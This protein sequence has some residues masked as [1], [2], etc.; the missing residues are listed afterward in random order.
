[1]NL[2][3]SRNLPNLCLLSL[4][5]LATGADASE[6]TFSYV[7][8][9]SVLAPGERELEPWTT[10]RLGRGG[11][12]ARF[13]QRLEFE[14]GLVERLQ[15]AWYLNFGGTGNAAGES[16]FEF[17]GV[18]WEWKYKLLDPV[19]DPVG[20]AVYLELG[21][22]PTEAEVEGKLLLDKKFGDLL[23]AL[24][25]VGEY[26]WERG[27][28]GLKREFVLELDAGISWK[29]ASGL[30]IGL[31]ARNHN[32]FVDGQWEHVAIFLGP[33]F[34]YATRSFWATLTLLP[35][36]YA[37][38]AEDGPG[39]ELHEHERLEARLLFGWHL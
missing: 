14:I 18:S 24:N 8:D 17:K 23:V 30:G 4:L 36:V 38:H 39:L 2:Q 9:S 16:A 5:L 28:E 13:D 22:G 26:E 11:Y 7:Y 31:E 20:F 10:V 1:M 21:G 25:V 12:F 15:T 37:P 29:T 27:P 3:I 32:E 33:S 6:R 34:S 19:A 35:Q